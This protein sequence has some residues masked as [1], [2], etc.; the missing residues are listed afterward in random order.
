MR[1][2]ILI[3]VVLALAACSTAK[4][5]E[6]VAKIVERKI[7]VPPSLLTCLPEPKATQVWRT[8]RDVALYLISLAEAGEDCR[9]RLDAVARILAE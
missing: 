3:L 1:F 2:T 6:P 5:P 7:E 8:Q 9:T 4:T